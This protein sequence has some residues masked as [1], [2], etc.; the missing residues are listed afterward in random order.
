MISLNKKHPFR[1][2]CTTAATF[3]NIHLIKQR[4]RQEN[5]NTVR[6]EGQKK[7][8]RSQAREATEWQ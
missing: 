8:L 3:E 1:S 4:P 5:D 2:K 6:R 7:S